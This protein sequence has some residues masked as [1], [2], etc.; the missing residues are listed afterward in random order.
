MQIQPVFFI[1]TYL[2]K[3][4]VGRIWL[5]GHNFL[6]PNLDDQQYLCIGLDLLLGE[7]AVMAVFKLGSAALWGFSGLAQSLGRHWKD[8][9]QGEGGHR[10]KAATCSW[11][12]HFETPMF[13]SRTS[14]RMHGYKSLIVVVKRLWSPPAPRQE[15]W[16]FVNHHLW[17][18]SSP[19]GIVFQVEEAGSSEF[20]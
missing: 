20:I 13:G 8:K 5:K 11:T 14:L 4:V 2:D 19:K 9:V 18:P 6:T 10:P 17:F 7:K 15:N 16:V 1:I 3:Q 12:W